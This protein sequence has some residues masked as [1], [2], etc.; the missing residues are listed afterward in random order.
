MMNGSKYLIVLCLAGALL[1]SGFKATRWKPLF[2]GKDLSGWTIQGRQQDRGKTFWTVEGGE[3]TCNSI[4]KKDHNHV[5][6][7]NNNEYEDFE[8]NLKFLA[9][10]DSPGNCGVQFRS[11]Y[12]TVLEGGRMNGPQVDIHPPEASSWRTGL[13]YDETLEEQRWLVPSLP[14]WNIPQKYKPEKY[15]FKYSE[16]GWNDLTIICKGMHVKTIV[17]GIVRT[18]WDGTE[19]LGNEAHRKRNIGKRGHIALQLHQN[20]ELKI[21][22]RDIRIREL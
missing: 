1:V 8:L 10:H 7:V 2:N 19:V 13:I 6:L 18:D 5:W 3:I 20:D 21:R 12:D 15:K 4:G 14:N 16:E 17:N 11:R 9:Y 22:F